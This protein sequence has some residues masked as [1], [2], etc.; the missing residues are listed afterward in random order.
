VGHSATYAVAAIAVCRNVYVFNI[1]WN[2][3][4]SVTN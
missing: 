1:N 2:D 4:R 3:T